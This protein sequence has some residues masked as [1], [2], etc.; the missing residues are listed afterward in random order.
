[1]DLSI[2]SLLAPIQEFREHR[3]WCRR[4]FAAPTPPSTKRIV[5]MR[6]GVC[7]ATWVETGTYRGDTA[8]ALAKT[9]S[10]VYTIE[11]DEALFSRAKSRFAG[12]RNVTVIHGLSEQVLPGL[13]ASLKGDINLWLDGHYSGGSTFQGPTDCPI[14]SELSALA[15]CLSRFDRVTVLIDDMRCFDP[16]IAEYRDYP[17]RARL[18]A[19]A[20]DHGFSWHIEHDIMC[21]RGRGRQVECFDPARPS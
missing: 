2:K 15:T 13:L 14:L 8:A 18:V 5:L 10:R 20:R 17:D 1:M 7:G 11:P 4:A 9:G 12:I 6:L 19:W 21:M 16:S 3:K